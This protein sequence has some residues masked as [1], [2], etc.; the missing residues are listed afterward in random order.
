M[1]ERF[2]IAEPAL[3][4]LKL[5]MK[6]VLLLPLL[7]FITFSLRAQEQPVNTGASADEQI[8]L[9]GLRLAEL[10]ARF[11]PPKSVFSAR[12]NEIWQDDVVFRYDREDFYIF[13]DRVWQVKFKSVR[14]V[15]V[16]D[17]KQAALLVFGDKAQNMGDYLLVPVTGKDWSLMIR[18]NFDK[19]DSVSA[20]YVYRQDF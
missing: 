18:V 1:Q 12:G 16:G 17:P 20:I 2:G 5:T 10:I 3:Y 4:S 19:A 15:S 9:V 11:G 7:L 14:G 13:G 8:S 6:R